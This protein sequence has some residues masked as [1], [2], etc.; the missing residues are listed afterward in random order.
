MEQKFSLSQASPFVPGFGSPA[1]PW[2][3]LNGAC[4]RQ[5]AKRIVRAM[6][7][8]DEYLNML[9]GLGYN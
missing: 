3:Y 5:L 4:G 6:I 8:D 9:V 7:V 2:Y 1:R